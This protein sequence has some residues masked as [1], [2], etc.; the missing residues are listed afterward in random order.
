MQKQAN[1]Q[2]LIQALNVGD[3]RTLANL[4]DQP[5][6]PLQGVKRADGTTVLHLFVENGDKILVFTAEL[7]QDTMSVYEWKECFLGHIGGDD[8]VAVISFEQAE[9]FAKRLIERFD[10]KIKL[11]YT[12]RDRRNGYVITKNR[13]GIEEKFALIT[14]S[15]AGVHMR[16]NAVANSDE[17]GELL[18]GIKKKCKMDWHSCVCIE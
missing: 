11:F 8:F 15:I 10:E 12:E 7:L 13:H 1:Q 14:I 4:V 16:K 6:E 3:M 9:V 2:Q 5:L 17:L 18:S